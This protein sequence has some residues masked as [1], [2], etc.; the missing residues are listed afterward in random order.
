MPTAGTW[1]AYEGGFH[2]EAVI[3]DKIFIRVEF[4]R[5]VLEI[6]VQSF[7]SLLE[8]TYSE[9][10]RLEGVSE[11][12]GLHGEVHGEMG[13]QG[14]VSGNLLLDGPLKSMC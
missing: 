2:G 14:V 6:R 1:G 11:G 4:G 3:G 7:T 10:G 12:T 13:R 5:E 8:F 9:R